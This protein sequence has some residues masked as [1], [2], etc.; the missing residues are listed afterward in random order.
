MLTVGFK[1]L[2]GRWG[3]DNLDKTLPMNDIKIQGDDDEDNGTPPPAPDVD[4]LGLPAELTVENLNAW[5]AGLRENNDNDT[6]QEEENSDVMTMASFADI[7][8][9]QSSES[10]DPPP[11]AIVVVITDGDYYFSTTEILKAEF[12]SDCPFFRA[13]AENNDQFAS[14]RAAIIFHILSDH[15]SLEVEGAFIMDFLRYNPIR[16]LGG[17]RTPST[18][19]HLAEI[20]RIPKLKI[21][22]EP[23]QA[24]RIRALVSSL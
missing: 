9:Y 22:A 1:V 4:N 15:I 21:A 13:L 11:D 23:L 10:D 12:F 18:I 24:R 19:Y 17:L 3:R 8:T 5:V 20:L 16:S 2:K 6:L 7:N 14:G